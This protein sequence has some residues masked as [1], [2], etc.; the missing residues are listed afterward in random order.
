MVSLDMIV[1]VLGGVGLFLLGMVIMTDGLK[2]LAGEAMRSV[3]IRF[4]HTPMSGALTGAATTALLQSSSATI[5]AAVGFVGAQLM[6]YPMAL[7]IIFGANAG[8]T[9]TGWLVV[10]LG[11]KLKLGAV[12]PPIILF[13]VAMRLF[14][15]GRVA[16]VG[17]TVAGFAL[18]FVGIE[19]LQQGMSGLERQMTPDFFPADTLLGRL[20]L[21]LIGI[22][23]TL[24][25]QSSSAGV[26]MAL[27]AV[28]AGAISFPQAAA[29]VIGMDVG[30]TATAV[31]AT[32]G[33]SDDSRRT[34]LSHVTY[35][36]VTAIGALLL[37][38]PFIYLVQAIAPAWFRANAEMA[39]VIFHSG[40][41]LIGVIAILP[42][43]RQFTALMMRLI[44]ESG[45]SFTRALDTALLKEP[46]VA[47]AAARSAILELC[48]G[49]FLRLQQLLGSQ[50]SEHVAATARLQL[51]VSEA[52]AYVD[53][54]HLDP[55]KGP[56]WEQLIALIHTLD[57]M[58]RLLVRCAE[59]ERARCAI[60]I[61][62]L[63]DPRQAL[64]QS[65]QVAVLD[66]RSDQIPACANS[67]R[68]ALPG[69]DQQSEAA[70]DGVMGQVARGQIE[71]PEGTDR[72]EA[73]RWLQ[74]SAMHV[75]RIT[76]HLSATVK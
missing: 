52:Q 76:S 1:Q 27:A 60:E 14:G 31:L 42:F 17:L 62:G 48:V 16:R 13:G 15:K 53:Q 55:D 5:V 9:I 8:T 39:L 54:I 73:I 34:G 61:D 50:P 41:N 43:T 51:A 12:M 69:I 74:R 66:I 33:A 25:T 71:V 6:T 35:N 2:S 59:T 19:A 56:D 64:I 29:L 49:V 18:I 30:T 40:F 37:L 44:P 10:L 72:L 36:I 3:L 57:H 24:V 32:I 63:A 47:L 7:G 45:A 67:I 75:D 20:Q 26:A 58:Q 70:R 11:F 46:Q 65:V 38:S 4:T 22:A 21:V 28:Y 23:I 68:S